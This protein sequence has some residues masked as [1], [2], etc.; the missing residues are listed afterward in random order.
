[1]SNEVKVEICGLWKHKDGEGRTFLKGR[2]GNAEIVI[3]PNV[4][5]DNQGGNAPDYRVFFYP[6]ERARKASRPEGRGDRRQGQRQPAG[7]P[8]YDGPPGGN[9]TED[10]IPF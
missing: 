8:D 6:G 2:L 3:L 1:L 10:D 5:K 7:A 4:F 9:F